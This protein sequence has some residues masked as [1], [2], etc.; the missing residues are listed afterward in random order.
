MIRGRRVTGAGRI[1]RCRRSGRLRRCGGRLRR[2]A[3]SLG[4]R[5]TVSL[6]SGFG[7]WS[8]RP[9]SARSVQAGAPAGRGSPATTRLASRPP[10]RAS[11]SP[12]QSR[13]GSRSRQVPV[14]AGSPWR[15]F[16]SDHSGSPAGGFLGLV[17]PGALAVALLE[18]GQPALANRGGVVGVHDRRLAPRGGAHVITQHQHPAQQPTE[19]PPP[20][21]HRDQVAPVR[22]GVQPAH[23][24]PRRR[25]AWQVRPGQRVGPGGRPGRRTRR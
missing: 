24:H 4:P 17:A 12:S 15:R 7:W 10:L 13:T 19:Q 8:L 9:A 5:L 18:R 20:R 22:G 16:S 11:P 21:V 25:R 6:R 1:V 14:A 23:P 3:Q 2:A